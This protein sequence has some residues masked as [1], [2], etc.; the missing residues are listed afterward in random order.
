MTSIVRVSTTA[1]PFTGEGS[2]SCAAGASLALSSLLAAFS[3]TQPSSSA[4]AALGAAASGAAAS[5]AAGFESEAAAGDGV[6]PPQ[7]VASAASIIV[8]EESEESEWATRMAP[9]TN[10]LARAVA[11]RKIATELCHTRFRQC[12]ENAALPRGRRLSRP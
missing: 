10:L 12:L 1:L 5:E 8:N 6:A 3:P 7:A 11:A 9:D 2:A 4:A